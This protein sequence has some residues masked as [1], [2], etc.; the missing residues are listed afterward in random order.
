M[1]RLL[2]LLLACGLSNAAF[3]A[4]DP[5]A[6][7]ALSTP[8]AACHGAEGK[9]VAPNYPNLAGQNQRYLFRQLRAIKAKTRDV[10]VM[11]GQLDALTEK[12]LQD[13]AAFYASK[14]AS[15]SQAPDNA[16]AL[17]LGER[18]YRGGLLDKQVAACAACHSPMGNGNAPAG[19]PLVRGQSVD[20]VAAQLTAY[21]EGVRKTD[22]EY[23]QMMRMI[24]SRL[25][26]GEIRAVAGYIQGLMTGQE[27]A[28]K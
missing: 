26:D 27:P 7:Q 22:E 20:Y 14:P 9:A 25:T 2:V 12:Q 4:G 24:A 11:A 15:I 3:A 28:A 17:A 10:A 21:R 5:A 8:C 18:I 19:F 16:D 23:G 13:L 6:G 1:R